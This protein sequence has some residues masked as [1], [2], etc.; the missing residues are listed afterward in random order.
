MEQLIG[1]PAAGTNPAGDGALIKDSNQQAFAQDVIE[2][3]MQVPVIVDFWA[4]WCGPC[5]QLGPAAREG[6][7]GGQR[8]GPAGQD[9]HRQE[10]GAGRA[11]AHPVDPGGLCLL[12]GP[13]GR[14][15]RRRAAGKPDQGVRR[16]AWPRWAA[17]G[18]GPSPVERGAGA[19]R[20]G[21]R[22]GRSRHGAARS[23]ARCWH[24][25]PD[26]VKAI[27]GLVRAARSPTGDLDAA[28]ARCWTASPRRKRRTTRRSPPPRAALELAERRP[29]GGRPDCSELQARIAAEP[30]GLTRRASISR[31]RCYAAGEREARST[32]CWRSSGATAPGTRRR[33]ASSW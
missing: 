15:L 32:S 2:A 29:G 31:W 25:E 12:P 5:K 7:Q 10:P 21:A 1:M 22:R 24:H 27:A 30:E 26:N 16:S 11:A 8:R 9:R 6:G 3:S 20:G 14:R 17:A 4:P 28:R 33:R 13:A 23:T 19:G 18:A